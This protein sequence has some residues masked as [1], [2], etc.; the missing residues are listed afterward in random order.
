MWNRETL[1]DSDFNSN[2]DDDE[3]EAERR[4][5]QKLNGR[6]EVRARETNTFCAHTHFLRLR[7]YFLF[8]SFFSWR[9]L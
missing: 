6:K 9:A 4:M 1:T 5:Q 2:G 8:V 7:V 3:A